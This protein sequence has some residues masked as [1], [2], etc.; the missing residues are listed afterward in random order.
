MPIHCERATAN[1]ETLTLEYCIYT[2]PSVSLG[3]TF[4]FIRLALRCFGPVK[5]IA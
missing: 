2:T 4:V 3:Q 5:E 1:E